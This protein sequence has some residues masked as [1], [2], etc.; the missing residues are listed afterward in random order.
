VDPV[1]ALLGSG[2]P[3]ALRGA[4]SIAAARRGVIL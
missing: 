1:S 4:I 3:D 2:R